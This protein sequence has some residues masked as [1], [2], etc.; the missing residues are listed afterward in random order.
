MFALVDCNSFYASCEQVFRPDLRGRP[1]VVLSNN[2]GFLVSR[3]KEA[4]A[5]GLGDLVPYFKVEDLIK[6][7][8]VAVFSSNYKLYG[9]I[10]SRVMTTLKAFSPHLEIYSID[11]LFL[12]LEGLQHPLPEYGHLIKQTVWQHTRIPVGVGIAKTKTLSKLANRGAKTIARCDGVCVLDT[13]HKTEWLL[14]HF[15][16]TKVWGIAGRL[17]ARLAELG[18]ATAWDLARSDAKTVRR[19]TSV[20]VERIIEELNGRPCLD[21]EEAPPA[22][23]QIYCTRSF[24]KR[25]MTLEPILEAVSLYSARA[26]EKLRQQRQLVKTLHVFLNNSPFE[27]GYYCGSTTVQL[28]YPTDDTRVISEHARAA[29]SRLYKPG[30]AY[31]KAGIGLIELIDPCYLQQDLWE[32][33]QSGQASKLMQL[34]DRINQHHGRRSV[35]LASQ[36]VHQPWYMKQHHR[37]PEYTTSWVDLPVVR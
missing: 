34:M 29:V 31:M 11:E 30:P 21:L 18:I 36:G 15:P 10:S 23:K 17:A 27:G 14:K 2:D 1:V 26:A 19:R 33:G 16:V 5:V 4:K 22:K 8:G 20:N 37:S 9:D 24:G 6:K 12:D 13:D 25:A 3:T 28:P 35:F 32:P 7:Y